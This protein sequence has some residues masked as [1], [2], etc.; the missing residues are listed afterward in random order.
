MSKRTFHFP[1]IIEQD[2]DG[3]YVASVPSLRGCHT[4]A[5]TLAE[6]DERIREAVALCIEA[7]NDAADW[8]AERVGFEPTDGDKPS[9]DF[10]SCAFNRTRPPLRVGGREQY[11][12][13]RGRGQFQRQDKQ[14]S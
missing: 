4:K 7:K 2:E 1:V 11:S 5:R 8:M 10:E 3:W 9:H 6:L 13:S 14:E 12:T